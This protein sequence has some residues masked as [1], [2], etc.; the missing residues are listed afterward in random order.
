MLVTDAPAGDLEPLLRP[1]EN[2]ALGYSAP[3][4]MAAHL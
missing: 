3:A 1:A 4:F 2:T